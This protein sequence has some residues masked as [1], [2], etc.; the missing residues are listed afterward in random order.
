MVS[1]GSKL[2]TSNFKG[3]SQPVTNASTDKKKLSSA[4][5]NILTDSDDDKGSLKKEEGP[6]KPTITSTANSAVKKHIKGKTETS[7]NSNQSSTNNTNTQNPTNNEGSDK[8]FTGGVPNSGT[9]GKQSR[10]DDIRQNGQINSEKER[11]TKDAEARGK[12]D[13]EGG[14]SSEAGGGGGAGA[15]SMPG[16]GGPSQ[17]GTGNFQNN[18]FIN[19]GNINF[20]NQGQIVNNPS[21][22]PVQDWP[23]TTQPEPPKP[24][25]PVQGIDSE[26]IT[27]TNQFSN[28]DLS[29]PLAMNE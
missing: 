25:S 27:N 8:P 18:G 7:T 17:S 9:D 23:G 26:L 21:S 6:K 2:T 20:G 15:F 19:N 1:T 28:S 12:I 10:F 14:A 3:P 4:D 16:T 11:L 5:I 13:K 24:P 29:K 22:P